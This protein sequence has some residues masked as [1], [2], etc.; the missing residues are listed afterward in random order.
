[1]KMGQ[2][3]L[4]TREDIIERIRSDPKSWNS[5]N[6]RA[7]VANMIPPLSYEDELSLTTYLVEK[8]IF[9]WL[10]FV[11]DELRKLASARILM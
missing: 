5:T 6:L 11:A 4:S 7:Y 1:M 10:D 2:F 3:D 8:N 9:L